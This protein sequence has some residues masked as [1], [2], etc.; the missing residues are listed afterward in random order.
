MKNNP[1]YDEFFGPERGNRFY[2]A[3]V[4]VKITDGSASEV[5]AANE[6]S[7]VD[8]QTQTFTASLFDSTEPAFGCPRIA[9]GKERAGWVT[10]EVPKKAKLTTFV[11]TPDAGEAVCV[12]CHRPIGPGEPFDLTIHPIARATSA[13]RIEGATAWRERR[14]AP[15]SRTRDVAPLSPRQ[16]DLVA[17]LVRARAGRRHRLGQLVRGGGSGRPLV[18]PCAESYTRP[19]TRRSDPSDLASNGGDVLTRGAS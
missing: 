6:T 15:R 1:P 2:A 8:S 12:R 4:K 3:Y 11:W 17:G 9:V 18:L 16:A 10:F 14:R 5:C 19:Q 7:V 13:S